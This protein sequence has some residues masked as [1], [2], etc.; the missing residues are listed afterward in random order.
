MTGGGGGGAWPAGGGKIHVTF[1][2]VQV[3][4]DLL[5]LESFVL[6]FVEKGHLLTK[7]K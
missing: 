7:E 6:S 3:R 5:C 4:S 2:S 1:S